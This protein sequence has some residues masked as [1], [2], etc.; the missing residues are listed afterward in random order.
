MNINAG[1]GGGNFETG[2]VTPPP[3]PKAG[4]TPPVGTTNMS[5]LNRLVVGENKVGKQEAGVAPESAQP[6]P[7]LLPP[8]Q[9]PDI[10]GEAMATARDDALQAPGQTL[11][12]IANNEF[13]PEEAIAEAA[14]RQGVEET[15]GRPST[16]AADGVEDTVVEDGTQQ[17]E[18]GLSSPVDADSDASSEGSLQDASM[19]EVS[20]Q[21][22]ATVSKEE[23]AN[24]E[25]PNPSSD[26]T[27]EEASAVE[28]PDATLNIAAPGSQ[29][30]DVDRN[31]VQEAS[32]IGNETESLSTQPVADTQTPDAATPAD[33]NDGFRAMQEA[34]V[35]STPQ[36][37]ET[38][39][40]AVDI[41]DNQ[42]DMAAMP[43]GNEDITAVDALDNLGNT[44]PAPLETVVAP[45]QSPDA[46]QPAPIPQS[47]AGDVPQPAPVP[48]AQ[49]DTQPSQ[50]VDPLRDSAKADLEAAQKAIEP[51]TQKLA[52]AAA[53][54]RANGED[55]LAQ[56]YDE[57]SQRMQQLAEVTALKN[58]TEDPANNIDQATKDKIAAE[59]GLAAA[60]AKVLLA[61]KGARERQIEDAAREID[62]AK[63]SQI[64]KGESRYTQDHLNEKIDRLKSQTSAD[65]LSQL[66]MDQLKIIQQLAQANPDTPWA[67]MI[68]KMDAGDN[69]QLLQQ[70]LQAESALGKARDSIL[71]KRKGLGRTNQEKLDDLAREID[72][73]KARNNY[74]PLTEDDKIDESNPAGVAL[75]NYEKLKQDIERQT[76]EAFLAKNKYNQL[77]ESARQLYGKGAKDT[78]AWIR[79]LEEGKKNSAEAEKENKKSDEKYKI[80]RQNELTLGNASNQL[81]YAWRSVLDNWKIQHNKDSTKAEKDAADKALKADWK[82]VKWLARYIV[83]KSILKFNK[84]YLLLSALAIAAAPLWLAK[85]VNEWTGGKG[86]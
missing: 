72:F 17:P 12:E 34:Q 19:Q 27:S 10:V 37:Q 76:L 1:P 52:E 39:Q 35:P 83:K 8:D 81:R 33:T 51:Q 86:G 71:Q 45:V 46:L 58:F 28:Q 32:T 82:E 22:V 84:W 4:A 55:R 62:A 78:Q 5:Q 11:G 24:R 41:V 18:E 61:N 48:D 16:E 31:V 80:K 29:T 23:T 75:R 73:Q 65:A 69:P 60:E 53:K 70:R 63:R 85:R 15:A 64:T 77:G 47:E 9:R 54:A 50:S 43:S 57:R 42:P 36:Q 30:S 74:N 13:P 25:A 38:T 49:P 7:E 3:A 59:H 56:V 44:S 66:P 2:G 40:P 6:Q 67:K 68:A 14:K 20:G 21:P 26:T 79:Q